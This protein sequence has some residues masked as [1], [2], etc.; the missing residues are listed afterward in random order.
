MHVLLMGNPNVGKSAIFTRLTGTHVLASNYSGT[1]VEY[2]R[3]VLK[4]LGESSELIDA[5][6]AFSLEPA[7]RAEK[8]AVEMLDEGDLIINVIDATNLERNLYLTLQLLQTGKPV[9][10]VLNMWDE[11]LEQGIEI[12]TEKLENELGIPVVTTCA[13]DGEGISVLTNRLDE[14]RAGT[15]DPKQPK[16]LWET[17]GQIVKKTERLPGKLPNT[18]QKFALSSVHPLAG[19]FIAALVL[20]LSFSFVAWFGDW[21]SEDI[22]E[23]LFTFLWLPVVNGTSALLGGE[24]V[25]HNILIGGLIDGRIDF[26][27]SFGLLTTGLFIPIAVVLPFIFSFYLVLSLLEDVGYLPRLGVLVDTVMR[28]MGV[29]GLSIVPMML[30]LGCNVPG[31]MS[32]RILETKKERFISATLM[33]I[34]VPCMAQQAMVIGLLGPAG[35]TGIVI[36]YSS[37]IILW[38]VVGVVMNFFVKGETPEMLIDLPPYRFPYWKSL[39]KKVYMRMSGF[40]KN[41]LPYVLLGVFIVNILYTFGL[42]EYLSRIFAPLLSTLFG[43]P[44]EAIG[45]LLIGFLRK[46]VAVGML[47][48]L[49]MDAGQLIVASF[50]LMIYFPCIATF[51]VLFKELGTRDLL[52]SMLIMLV[53]VLT[54]GSGLHLLIQLAGL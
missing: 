7:N 12:D 20:L 34:C 29:H 33:S 14:A 37:L 39:W 36:V 15:L 45:A 44:G 54:A 38:V 21:L 4:S 28:R 46:D 52:K 41:A 16:D 31:A 18:W 35:L 11:V 10:L 32:C 6:G 13:I 48:P 1:T 51:V 30:G 27:Q 47:A 24:G 50:V 3:G 40:I 26:E 17:A 9:I 25:I 43:L 42:F 23:Q 8:V 22:M 19:P 5:P 49:G 53:V 2:T